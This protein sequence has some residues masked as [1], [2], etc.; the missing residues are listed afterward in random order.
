MFNKN[1]KEIGSR[2]SQLRKEKGITQQE[3]AWKLQMTITCLSRY[4]QGHRMPR[5]DT[6]DKIAKIFNVDL[7]Y[8]LD[9]SNSNC[10]KTQDE[11][12]NDKETMIAEILMLLSNSSKTIIADTK[13]H[14][15]LL[16]FKEQMDKKV[17]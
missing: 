4:E 2:I 13:K 3:L 6:I 17:I 5:M 15:E 7:N 10:K 11:R 1:N 12:N 8:F 14:I 9:Y 16:I